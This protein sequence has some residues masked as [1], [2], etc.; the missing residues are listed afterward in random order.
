VTGE[1]AAERFRHGDYWAGKGTYGNGTY[2]AEG[3]N[4]AVVY[5]DAGNQKN[6]DVFDRANPYAARSIVHMAI[7]P[8]ARVGTWKDVR[9]EWLAANGVTNNLAMDGTTP[10]GRGVIV[11]KTGTIEEASRRRLYADIGRYAAAQGYDAIR[12]DDGSGFWLIFNRTALVVA[13]GPR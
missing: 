8:E 7:R 2:V 11:Q 6:G 12:M 9:E 5:S 4:V 1:Q 3:R 10:S 13:E